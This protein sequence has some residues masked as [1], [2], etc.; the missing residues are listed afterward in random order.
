MRTS[1]PAST[2]HVVDLNRW[3]RAFYF[4]KMA[5]QAKTRRQP[6]KAEDGAVYRYGRPRGL[7]ECDNCG[8]GMAIHA[9]PPG[10][11]AHIGRKKYRHGSETNS[12]HF[13]GAIASH[14]IRQRKPDQQTPASRIRLF[15]ERHARFGC[16]S[17]AAKR[18]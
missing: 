18:D 4:A 11:R 2:F 12:E 13:A 5:G 1:H 10:V 9:A 14:A 3:R 16:R 8:R 7:K 6:K 17:N 15:A